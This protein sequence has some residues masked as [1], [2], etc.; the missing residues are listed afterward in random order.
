MLSRIESLETQLLLQRQELQSQSEKINKI[1]NLLEPDS[2]LT[3]SSNNYTGIPSTASDSC[4]SRKRQT[5]LTDVVS[6]SR[7][8]TN[9]ITKVRNKRKRAVKATHKFIS[10]FPSFMDKSLP[11]NDN[12]H[13]NRIG[14]G[15]ESS[16]RSDP[17]LEKSRNLPSSQSHTMHSPA[18]SEASD[19][20]ELLLDFSSHPDIVQ[21]MSG[22]CT[23][24]SRYKFVRVL[25]RTLSNSPVPPC[26]SDFYTS[27]GVELLCGWMYDLAKEVHTSLSHC[28]W[29]ETDSSANDTLLQ[30]L[31]SEDFDC[32][33]YMETLLQILNKV[34]WTHQKVVSTRIDK[35]IRSVY[36]YFT[37]IAYMLES[38]PH[39]HVSKNREELRQAYI[40]FSIT[41][42]EPWSRYRDILFKKVK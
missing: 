7:K 31:S 28:Q 27:Q 23:R 25:S 32:R 16:I 36:K 10:T 12:M 37:A 40:A 33:G 9:T 13:K 19:D 38:H 17:L 41:L 11:A 20:T 30:R 39:P 15:V 21:Y 6:S 29:D 24:N 18:T 34:E 5:S 35:A 42:K 14:K 26:L 1:L 8:R 3:Y 4:S 22:K 2:S